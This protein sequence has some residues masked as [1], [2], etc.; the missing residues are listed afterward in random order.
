MELSNSTKQ[1]HKASWWTR[2]LALTLALLMFG[3]I[4]LIDAIQIKI[5]KQAEAEKSAYNAANNYLVDSTAYVSKSTL[6]RAAQVIK[7]AV[8]KPKSLQDFY[9]LASEAIAKAEYEKALNCIDVCIEMAEAE[10]VNAEAAIKVDLYMKKA[11]ILALL[12]DYNQALDFFDRVLEMDSTQYQAYLVKIQILAEQGKPDETIAAILSYL[13][14][15]PYDYSVRLAL[16]QLYYTQGR[17]AQAEAACSDYI[18]ETTDDI[19]T[20]YFMRGASRMQNGSF[21]LSMEDLILAAQ[22]G[23]VDAALCYGQAAICAY[24]LEKNEEVLSLGAQAISIGSSQLDFGLLYSYMGYSSMLLEKYEDATEQFTKAMEFGQAQGQMLY[25]RG[26][27]L[28]AREKIDDAIAD[29][30]ASL[31]AGES[32]VQCYYNR[33]VCYLKLKEYDKALFDLQNVVAMDEDAE[34]TAMAQQLIEQLQK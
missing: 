5:Q 29:F 22:N 11:C 15:K 31:L 3:S 28:M 13:E 21:K 23:Y 24:L 18:L 25:Y 20:V 7:E 1:K 8:T 10:T 32:S 2:A 17:F 12:N 9:N 27:S 26:V 30:T 33:A 6:E 16:I 34:L 14:L 4:L 19:A